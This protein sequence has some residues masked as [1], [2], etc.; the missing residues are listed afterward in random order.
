MLEI[1][2]GV[3]IVTALGGV[4]ALEGAMAVFNDKMD[5]AN[6]SKIKKIKNKADRNLVSVV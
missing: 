5:A 3:D 2:K 1:G 4:T 6:L